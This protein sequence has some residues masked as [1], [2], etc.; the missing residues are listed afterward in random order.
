MNITTVLETRHSFLGA[1]RTTL[2]HEHGQPAAALV[3]P[4]IASQWLLTLRREAAFTSVLLGTAQK[5]FQEIAS[6]AGETIHSG[7]LMSFDH[8][9]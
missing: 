8:Q 7:L 3:L 9:M 5:R 2:A 6:R 4:R 1:L